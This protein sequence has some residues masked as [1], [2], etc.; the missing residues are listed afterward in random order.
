LAAY[1]VNSVPSASN[2]VWWLLSCLTTTVGLPFFITS[3]NGPL[4]QRW[5]ASTGLKS[6]ADPYFLYSASNAG[7]FVALLAYPVFLEPNFSLQSQSRVWLIGY[8]CLLFFVG[9]C[10]VDRE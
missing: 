6:A 4:L 2:P 10:A 7:S 9:L 5:F 3:S 1:W 8:V